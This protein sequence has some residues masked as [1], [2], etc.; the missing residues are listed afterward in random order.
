MVHHS[1]RAHQPARSRAAPTPTCP[2]TRS[3]SATPSRSASAGPTVGAPTRSRVGT[4]AELDFQ[5]REQA[6]ELAERARR[7]GHRDAAPRGC[8]R[9]GGRRRARGRAGRGAAARASSVRRSTSTSCASTSSAPSR[10]CPVPTA[11]SCTTWPRARAWSVVR[12]RAFTTGRPRA[13]FSPARWC[14][15]ISTRPTSS[16]RADIRALAAYGNAAAAARELADARKI[17]DPTVRL[18]YLRDQFVISG[19]QLNSVNVGVSLPL[20]VF[21]HGQ[22]ER[23]SAEASL[24]HLND[25]R[26]Q[27]LAVAKARIPALQQRRTLSLGA[28]SAPRKA[29]LAASP[30]RARRSGAS[31]RKSSVAHE[32]S[33]PGPPRSQRAVHRR[34]GQLR[35]RLRGGARA[36]P[37]DIPPKE[38]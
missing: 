5:V 4:R 14:A 17:P 16:Q 13:R 19:N 12:A 23:L 28:L 8:R 26:T 29:G 33:H 35:R 10:S 30:R 18:G 15:T 38:H 6:L 37:R 3:A 25:E 31:R 36:V 24:R 27:R 7:P 21:D 9:A 2:T 22:G 34:S 11:T 20:P 32:S 1:G